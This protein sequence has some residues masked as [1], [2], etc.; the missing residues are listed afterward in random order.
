MTALGRLVARGLNFKSSRLNREVPLDALLRI[1]IHTP[2][3]VD[4]GTGSYVHD[5]DSI[6]IRTKALME[7]KAET[8]VNRIKV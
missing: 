8:C 6:N 2:Q 1:L 4:L 5:L 3:L 7:A